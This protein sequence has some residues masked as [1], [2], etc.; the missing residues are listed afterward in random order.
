M[1]VVRSKRIAG[2]ADDRAAM[3]VESDKAEA[4]LL[5]EGGKLTAQ[6]ESLQSKLFALERS[7]KLSEKRLGE[8][9]EAVVQLRIESPKYRTDEYA[10]RLA[11]ISQGLGAECLAA[12]SD[13]TFLTSMLAIDVGNRDS[14]DVIRIHFP[15]CVSIDAFHKHF[16]NGQAWNAQLTQ[17]RKRLNELR[18]KAIAL[19]VEYDSAKSE[20][21]EL[22]NFYI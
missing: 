1:R 15:L 10:S 7:A 16:V 11:H 8:M 4:L 6:I 9:D 2:S 17:L 14:V 13:V 3:K 19:R 22:L 12:E 5:S 21:E 20:I 18:P